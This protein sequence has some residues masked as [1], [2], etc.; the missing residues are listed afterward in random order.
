VPIRISSRNSGRVGAGHEQLTEHARAPDAVGSERAG[1]LQ[2]V[3]RH[4]APAPLNAAREA[5]NAAGAKRR[6]ANFS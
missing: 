6:E 2:V 5:S 4:G 3:L 1:H